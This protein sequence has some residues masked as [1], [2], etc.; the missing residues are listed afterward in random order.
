MA[1]EINRRAVDAIAQ[2]LL[3]PCQRVASVLSKQYPDARVENVGDVAHDVLR[4]ALNRLPPLEGIRG[5]DP[6][7]RTRFALVT[8]HRAELVDD[9]KK[10]EAVVEALS[11]SPVPCLFP[12]P[13]TDGGGS[14]AP[15]GRARW[16][17]VFDTS[18]GLSRK[19]RAAEAGGLRHHRLG[20]DSAG[21][22]LARGPVHYGSRGDGVGGDG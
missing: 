2:V 22:L 12:S 17:S 16:A 20:R 14:G 1:E 15:E 3:A 19:Y 11:R 4:L 10:L 5:Y 21:S 13:S 6:A 18:G 9:A 8:L 7:W